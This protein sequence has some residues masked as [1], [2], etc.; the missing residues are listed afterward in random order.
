MVA[1]RIVSSVVQRQVH[2]VSPVAPA[3]A[4]GVVA[5]VYQQVAE[6]L[7]LVIPPVLL[8]SPSPPSL[9]AYWM[10][11]R[12]PL[13]TGGAVDRLAKEAVAAAVAVANVC[14]YCVDMHS[15]GMYELSTADDAEAIVA[16]RVAEI[17]DRR[18]RALAWWARW[19]HQPGEVAGDQPAFT[20]AERAELVG[21]VVG[22]HYLSRMVNVFLSGYLLPPRL[23]PPA[24]RRVKQGVSR[25]LRPSLRTI[26]P[27]GRAVP[28]L[29]EAPLPPEADW[30]A[31]HSDVAAAVARSAAAFEAAGRRALSPAVRELL[32]DRLES[33]RGESPG[34]GR[35]WWTEAV[36]GLPAADR[37][38]GRLALL[39]AF[40]SYQ[41]DE[42]TVLAFRRD[43][44]G[45][46]EL[47][48]AAAWAS[49]A[50]AR[51]VG[52]WHRPG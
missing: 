40:A 36:A 28:L 37:A 44:P 12:E 26:R 42:E 35:R 49:F 38:A 27:P 13:L 46:T 47:V 4:A 17:A 50:A 43:Q 15:I 5:A 14:P 2:H 52:R 23:A 8:H 21:V 9:A 19:A 33:W 7:G 22:F 20:A 10:L 41:V 11:M 45:D 29:P 34:P 32:L 6:E 25:L 16:D 48:E 51:R 39:T 3:A 1:R 31:G 24:R 30:A 18:V